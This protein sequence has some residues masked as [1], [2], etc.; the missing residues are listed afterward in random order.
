LLLDIN[1]IYV[2]ARNHQFSAEHYI[3]TIPT[4]SVREIHLAGHTV[5]QFDQTQIL[6]DTHNARVADAVWTLYQSAA[7][8]FGGVPVLIEWDA[9]IPPLTVL[10]EEAAKAQSILN[11]V[12]AGEQNERI[13]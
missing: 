6:I 1:N 10:V 5:K 7:L 12:A 2:N 4:E 3:N 9:D 13:A 8:R 11:I